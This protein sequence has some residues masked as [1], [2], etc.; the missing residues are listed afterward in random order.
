MAHSK[1]AIKAARQTAKRT[2][3]NRSNKGKVRSSIKA[4][5]QAV[6]VKD[7]TK[8]TELL[9]STISTIDKG[10]QKRVLHRNAAARQKSRLTAQ[11]AK[12]S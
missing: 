2:Q 1:S 12:L 10:I 7:K 8:A 9:Q 5:R 11:V 4:L 6:S 3:V